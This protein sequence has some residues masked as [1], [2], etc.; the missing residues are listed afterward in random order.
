MSWVSYAQNAEDVVLARALPGP[1]GFYV[2]V[3]AGHPEIASVTKHFYELGWCGINIEPRLG[4]VALLE[5]Q[6]PRDINLGIAAGAADGEAELFVVA[7]DPDL[8]TT[9]P[10]DLA[11]LR[12]RGYDVSVELVEVRTLDRVL[13]EHNVATIDFLKIDVEGGEADVLAGI[14]LTRWEP[15]VIVV[16]SVKP[17]SHERTDT[18]WRDILES[19]GYREACFDGINLFFAREHDRAVAEALAPAS[20]LDDYEPA[21][22][23]A[24]RAEL[25]QLRAYIATLEQELARHRESHAEV[26]DYV[27]SLEDQLAA[28]DRVA[29]VIDLSNAQP[30]E[31]NPR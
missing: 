13:D 2:D 18:L 22:N 23:A 4:A 1:T 12:E 8:S 10:A 31:L 3:G 21:A 28:A 17:W 16:E 5:E 14:D 25:D 19:H 24:I 20:V 15:R 6:R 29:P 30:G 27:R 26:R 9:D 11:L 7:A